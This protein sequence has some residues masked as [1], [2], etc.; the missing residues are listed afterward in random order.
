MKTQEKIMIT[1]DDFS[2]GDLISVAR[3]HAPLELSMSV[4]K[5]I[6]QG[7]DIVERF[8]EEE[9]VIYGI[10]TG[11]GENSKIKISTSDS[12]ELQKNIIMSHACGMGDPLEKEIVRAIMVMMIKNL[13]L[14]YSGVRLET[15]ERL[16]E[17]V[18]KDV[19]PFVP[20][21]GSLGYLNHQAHISLVLLGM[22]EAYNQGVL[23]DGETALK[24]AGIKPIELHEKEGLSLINGT[25]DMT[26]IGALAVYDAINVLKAA[27]IVSIISFEALKGTY[28]AFDP[29]I[30]KV[31]RHPGQKKTTDNIHKLIKN[32]E[33]TEKFKDYRTQDALSIR[34]IPQVHG[35]CKDAVEYVRTIV[36]REMNSASD[37]PL[38]FDDQEGARA[39][40]SSNCHGEA[41]A[42]AMDFL[43]ISLSELANISERRIFRLVSPQHSELPP[44]LIEQSGLNSGYMIPQYVA[45]SLVSNNKVYSHPSSVDS[46][47]TTGGQEDHVSMG[48]S[49][50]LKALKVIANTEKVIGIEWMCSCQGIEFHQPLQPG[51]GTTAACDLFRK[52]VPRLEQ[53][54]ILYK[55][56][57]TA[58]ELVHSAEIVKHVEAKIGPLQF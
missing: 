33:I 27:D 28:Y 23:T 38:V 43:A 20:Q 14:G 51:T 26:A 55:D 7:R 19:I 1:E 25:V 35:A 39:I 56:M 40:S 52:Y 58:A 5:R 15:V 44:Y 8:V 34:S 11:V 46:I 37:N 10:T 29:K 9:R 16:A 2:I 48:T 53:D 36:E 22:G 3:H 13:S 49:A 24:K 50:A 30:S 42:L 4:K 45:A 57:R 17:M 32:S 47:P 41:I 6:S 21:E 31:K 12:R 54:R 18:N